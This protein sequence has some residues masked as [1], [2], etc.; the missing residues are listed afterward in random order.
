M[1]RVTK[2]E[3]RDNRGIVFKD[4]ALAHKLLDGKVGLEIGAS[5][6]NPFN[7]SGSTHVSP[8]DDLEL[9]REEELDKCG[10]YAEIDIIAE[11]DDLPL[12]DNSQ[13]YVLTSHVFEH[14]PNPIKALNEWQRV[15]KDG[16][17]VFMIVPQRD[18]L[19]SDRNRPLSTYPEWVIS[20]RNNWTVDT[21]NGISD[22]ARREHYY[23]YTVKTL[24]SMIRKHFP[25]WKRIA[26]EKIDRKAGNGFTLVY[27]V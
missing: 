14:L 23:V 7:L 27:R 24:D 21:W 25:K 9:Y 20:F 6:H 17:I 1:V 4:H 11:A 16:G 8:G 22:V 12:P 10:A 2:V 5:A 19:E 3:G 26:R 18:A 15:L 13:D